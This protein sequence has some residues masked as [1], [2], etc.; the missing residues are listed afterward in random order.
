MPVSPGAVA[1]VG[2][3]IIGRLLRSKIVWLLVGV[4]LFLRITAG[5]CTTYVPPNMV[6]VR[7]SYYGSSAGIHKQLYWP[8]LHF[9]M[10]GAERLHLFPHDLQL[11]NFTATTSE[12]TRCSST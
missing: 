6:G 2:A 5:A 8:G 12:A 10:A 9:V 4:P 11:I 3:R 7:Q 1:G